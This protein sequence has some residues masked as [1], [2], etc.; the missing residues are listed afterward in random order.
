M[1]SPD[2]RKDTDVSERF[3]SFELVEFYLGWKSETFGGNFMWLMPLNSVITSKQAIRFSSTSLKHLI[4]FREKSLLIS[5]I[6]HDMQINSADTI[7]RCLLLKQMMY[8][9]TA[10]L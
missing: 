3:P 4:P 5:I 10:G 2:I 8:V 7:V 9:V 6:R 1:R